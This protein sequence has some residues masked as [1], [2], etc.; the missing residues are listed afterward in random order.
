MCNA[1]FGLAMCFGIAECDNSYH[2]PTF[3]VYIVS[4]AVVDSHRVE[5]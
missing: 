2:N 1:P 3:A 5:L 4:T